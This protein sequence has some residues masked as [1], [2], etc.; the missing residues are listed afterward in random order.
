MPSETSVRLSTCTLSGALLW[1]RAPLPAVRWRVSLA[2]LR[3]ERNLLASR[4]SYSTVSEPV[5]VTI[6]QKHCRTAKIGTEAY[7]ADALISLAHV[8]GHGMTGMS[9][10]FKNIGMGLGSR[11]GKQAVHCAKD[12]PAVDK[13][14]CVGCAECVAHC[15]VN[16]IKLV[17]RKAAIDGETCMRC[18]ECTVVCPHGAIA[19]R[20]DDLPR[21]VQ[22][23]IVE[24][25]YAALKN[26]KNK[27]LFYNF[28]LDIT[29]S[30]LCIR[31]SER[32]IVQDIGI[33]ASRDPVALEQAT[34]DLVKAQKGLEASILPRAHRKGADKYKA[35]YPGIDTERTMRY[36]EEIGLGVRK[37][38]LKEI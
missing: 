18:G 33:L 8:H 37:Y 6:N 29:P 23:R 4:A 3:T 25:T 9:A 16:A 21:L 15:P 38:K 5:E 32:P 10:T 1:P 28:A 27:C 24:Y 7:Y 19:A 36:A 17:H 13:E 20:Y 26:K 12:A 11:G 2:K 34:F 14:K 22:E 30:C 35:L 31:L